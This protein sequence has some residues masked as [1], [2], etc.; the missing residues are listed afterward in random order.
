MKKLT[1][2]ADKKLFNSILK[3]EKKVERFIYP[4]NAKR[5]VVEEESEDEDGELIVT[6]TPVHYDVLRLRNGRKE[7][8][9]VIEVEVKESEFVI[10]T[11][12][13]GNDLTFEENGEEFYVCQ[14]WYTLGNILSTE[15]IPN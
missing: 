13:N 11:D 12:E 5:Y 15:N 6:V 1:L 7:N 3:G 8:A 2:Q 14:V 9:P 10:L 4:N